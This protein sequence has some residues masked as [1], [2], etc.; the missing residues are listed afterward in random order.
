MSSRSKGPR[1]EV[2]KKVLKGF[3]EAI[4]VLIDEMNKEP[5]VDERFEKLKKPLAKALKKHCD[6]LLSAEYEKMKNLNKSQLEDMD[7]KLEKNAALDLLDVVL[8]LRSK[9]E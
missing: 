4:E 6:N 9:S 1:G 7:K 2:T 8:N 5:A 3:G